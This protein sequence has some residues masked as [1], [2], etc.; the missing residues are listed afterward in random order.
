MAH[1]GSRWGHGQ[2]Q[3]TEGHLQLE[4]A[5]HEQEDAGEA[6]QAQRE[7][8]EQLEEQPLP[9]RVVELLSPGHGADATHTL[10]RQDGAK[11]GPEGLPLPHTQLPAAITI[12][13]AGTQSQKCDFPP[14]PA[15]L[16]HTAA[17]PLTSSPL[18]SAGPAQGLLSLDSASH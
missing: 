1:L 3:G 5:E 4:A 13:P 2:G 15:C 10:G 18:L 9:G 11:L 14:L 7:A 6:G 16:P 12:A 8:H 17:L